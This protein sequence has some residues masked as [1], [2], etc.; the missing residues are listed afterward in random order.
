MFENKIIKDS[1]E[2]SMIWN[3]YRECRY[4]ISNNI[5]NPIWYRF[6]GHK[7]H[8]VK[9]KL[10][11]EPWYDTDIRILYS[12]M[13]LVEWFVENDMI[14]FDEEE[15]M[16]E[17]E[18]IDNEDSFVDKKNIERESVMHQW[19]IDD[20]IMEIYNWW[21]N[22]DKR[23]VEIEEAYDEWYDFVESQRK[24][25]EDYLTTLFS[26]SKEQSVI[27]DKCIQLE[28]KL[29]QEEDEMLKKAIELRQY[30]WS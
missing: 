11:P 12:V 29:V 15:R 30:M 17:L 2:P 13:G 28:E 9:T 24:E 6:F 16:D 26:I 23:K 18:R 7:H 21:K 8:I 22:Y 20:K 5:F 3:I 4:F 27:R 1:Y 19:A 25:G 14:F 10:R